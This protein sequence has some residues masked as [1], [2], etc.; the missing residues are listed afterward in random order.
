MSVS[1]PIPSP[2]YANAGANSNVTRPTISSAAKVSEKV[3]R[4]ASTK[5]TMPVPPSSYDNFRR[6][7]EL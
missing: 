5:R 2:S 3:S 4:H 6:A 7:S 1:Q